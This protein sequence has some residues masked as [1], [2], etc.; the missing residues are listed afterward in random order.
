M[1][2]A[3][4]CFQMFQQF[5]TYVASVL[6]ECCIGHTRIL[7]VYVFKYFQLF[8]TY[9]A[10]VLFRCCSGHTHMLQAYVLNVS[11]VFETYVAANA[12]CCKCSISRRGKWAQ[13]EQV[14]PSGVAV[15]AGA[16]SE[17]SMVA[18]TC[19]R[20]SNR[21]CTA[22]VGRLARQAQQEQRAGR[23]GS[24]SIVR[25]G[26]DRRRMH[27]ERFES[28]RVTWVSCLVGQCCV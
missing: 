25:A 15:P 24:S 4:V 14:V 28:S 3:N 1:Y 16:R 18:P 10:S 21:M 5:Q 2:A 7:Q 26:R 6:S 23:C 13:A 22:V 11:S 9:V 17:V 19:M 27:S 12:T 20:S 8:Q